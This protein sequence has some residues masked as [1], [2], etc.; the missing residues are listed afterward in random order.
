MSKKCRGV[1]VSALTASV[2]LVAGCGSG[3]TNASKS[4]T[5]PTASNGSTSSAATASGNAVNLSF[6][7]GLTGPDR[8]AIEHLVSEF[9]A[10]HPAI[11]IAMQIMP[12]DVLYQKLLPAYGAKQ[13]PDLVGMDSN[14]LPVYA[15]KGVLQPLD[16]FFDQD[17]VQKSS[18]VAPALA[19]GTYQGRVFGVPIESTPVV[20]YYNKK[21][22]TAAGLDPAKPPTTWDQWAADAKKLTSGSGPG[23]KPTKY[24]LA[25]GVHD[26]VEVMPILMWMA[27][28]GILSEDG[29][30][31]LLNSAGSKQ[32][33]QKWADL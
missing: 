16:P 24:G 31:V 17:G 22:F 18:L 26:T 1:F 13:G 5:G 23:G 12:W 25:F 6:W 28:G 7:N 15:S 29:R 8:P 27:D 32:A 20:L 2:L 21:I 9:N 3:S 30:Q 33:V 19:A 11:H 10:S 14:Q 4:S